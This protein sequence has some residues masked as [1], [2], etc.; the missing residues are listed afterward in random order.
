MAPRALDPPRERISILLP[1]LEEVLRLRGRIDGQEACRILLKLSQIE[2][3]M[4]GR[5]LPAA[6][7]GDHRF[8]L[9]EDGSVVLAALPSPSTLRLEDL[10][11][12][13]VDL[14]TTGGSA[15]ADRII[16]VGAV[17]VHRGRVG[18]EFSTLLNPCVPIPPFI[19]SMTGIREE[20]VVRAPCFSE[21]ADR[22]AQFLGES[23]VVAHNLPFDRS[24]LN[25]AF[26]RHCGFVLSN[27]CLC[28][29]RLGRRLLSHLPDRR[30][31]TVADHYGIPIEARHRALGDARATAIIL[32]RLLGE[33]ADRGIRSLDQVEAFLSMPTPAGT[34]GQATGRK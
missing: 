11:F 24:F 28:T 25:A 17:R 12:T 6:L 14:E 33:L 27:S 18:E 23:V 16:E 8:R 3:A 26:S 7:G 10:V 5:I 30:L 4:A 32:L 9:L 1:R 22:L 21:M 15:S 2:P 31:D 19:L 13:V 29:V 20:M 34:G